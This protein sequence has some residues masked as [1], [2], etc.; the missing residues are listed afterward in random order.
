[1]WQKFLEWDKDVFVYLNAL[2]IEKYDPFWSAVTTISTWIP[3]F[4]LFFVLVW[5]KYPK[6]E[7]FFVSLTVVSLIFFII[8]ATDLSKMY[9][10]RL[11]PNNE[12]EINTLIRILR[13]PSSYSFFSGHASSS[14]SVTTLVFLFLRKRFAYS[15][16]FFIWPLLFT[17][18]RIYVGVHYPSDILV[19]AFV[20]ISSAYLFYGL[21]RRLIVPYLTLGRP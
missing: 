8:V 21:Y 18:S 6:K 20:G 14:F 4:V 7:A 15:L 19:G 11:R 10:A 16:L 17:A 5:H 12:P 2:G 9:F 3:L 13:R 1:M